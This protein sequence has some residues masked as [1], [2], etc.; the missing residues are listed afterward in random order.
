[1]DNNPV[2]QRGGRGCMWRNVKKEITAEIN[3]AVG[4]DPAKAASNTE[5]KQSIPAPT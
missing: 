2:R 3:N 4:T 5:P 1:M